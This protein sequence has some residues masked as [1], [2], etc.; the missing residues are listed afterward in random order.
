MTNYGIRARAAQWRPWPAAWS[1]HERHSRG[2]PAPS[3]DSRT[4]AQPWWALIHSGVT[5]RQRSGAGERIS[6]RAR[7]D[8]LRPTSRTTI[9]KSL[10]RES[11]SGLPGAARG[12]QSGNRT[13]CAAGLAGR[14]RTWGRGEGFHST[15]R[16]GQGGRAALRVCLP[17]AGRLAASPW[18]PK[19]HRRHARIARLRRQRETRPRFVR[20]PSGTPQPHPLLAKR[21][22]TRPR[23][24]GHR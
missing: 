2:A 3:A 11:A 7:W 12:P 15:A 8:R 5:A 4:M 14:R 10:R 1:W 9:G 18:N 22:P 21:P 19:S 16:T 23:D 13:R 17:G 24:R 6:Q 20:G